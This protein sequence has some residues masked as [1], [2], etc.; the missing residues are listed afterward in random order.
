M[1]IRNLLLSLFA[2]IIVAPAWGGSPESIGWA[3]VTIELKGPD[4][5]VAALAAK[6]EKDPVHKAASCGPAKAAEG[7]TKTDCARADSGL[8]AYL[9]KNEL[10]TV[11]WSISSSDAGGRCPVG[12]VYMHCPPPTGPVVCCNTA[13]YKACS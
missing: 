10:A 3:G 1:K 5:S 2:L 11:Q 12:C 6:L 7:A 4:Q 8:M 13:T 9:S